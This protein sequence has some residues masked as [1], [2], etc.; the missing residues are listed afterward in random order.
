MKIVI[1]TSDKVNINWGAKGADEIAQNVLT[2]INTF[3]YE[4]AYDRTIGINAQFQDMPLQEAVANITAQI[5]ELI[6]QR[7]PRATV[8]EVNF[9][10]QSEDGN[11]AFE[12]V[13]DV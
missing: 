11:L 10:G 7:E 13:I 8:K 12:V 1:N 2:L 5:Y 3:T 4:V 9:I 6:E